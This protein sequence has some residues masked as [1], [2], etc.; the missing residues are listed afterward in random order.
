MDPTHEPESPEVIEVNEEE[1]YA[2]LE[3]LC[4]NTGVTGRIEISLDDIEWEDEDDEEE[5]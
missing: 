4:A 3:F 2:I 1:G 5:D